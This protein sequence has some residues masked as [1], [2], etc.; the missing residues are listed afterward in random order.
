MTRASKDPPPG[1]NAPRQSIEDWALGKAKPAGSKDPNK[2]LTLQEIQQDL[3]E[4]RAD[5]K[6]ALDENRQYLS[7]LTTRTMGAHAEPEFK[8]MRMEISQAELIAVTVREKITRVVKHLE[9][10]I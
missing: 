7:E 1:G 9:I 3:R 4:Q 2:I 10:M 6:A 5:M 8:K